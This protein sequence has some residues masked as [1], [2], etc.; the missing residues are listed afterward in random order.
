MNR[1]TAR[2]V[3]GIYRDK[4]IEIEIGEHSEDCK[5]LVNGKEVQGIFG[6]HIHMRAGRRTEIIMERYNL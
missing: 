6:V 4:N 1:I 2:G 3:K 5:I